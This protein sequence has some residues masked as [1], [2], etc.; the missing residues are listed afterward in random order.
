MQRPPPEM[1]TLAKRWVP[2]SNRTTEAWGFFSAAEMA[3]KN[4]AAPPPATTMRGVFKARGVLGSRPEARDGGHLLPDRNRPFPID[5]LA[6]K[7]RGARWVRPR[8]G[9]NGSGTRRAAIH[10][11]STSL[12][13]FAA[14]D[15]PHLDAGAAIFDRWPETL[16]RREGFHPGSGGEFFR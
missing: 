3:P 1:R 15:K 7:P 9:K 14:W 16:G 13:R 11:S 2:F 6:P 12:N 10:R 5:E 4:P 8:F